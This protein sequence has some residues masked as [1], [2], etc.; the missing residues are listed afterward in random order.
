SNR[1]PALVSWRS[2]IFFRKP[3]PTFRDHALDADC[4]DNGRGREQHEASMRGVR[5][6]PCIREDLMS[7]SRRR[8][9]E[10]SL[11]P[12][13]GNGLIDRR[14]LL[15]R[16]IAFAGAMGAAGT[17]T[18]AAAEP[19]KDE[20]WSLEFGEVT[21]ALQTPSQFEKNVVRSL[22]NPNGEFR[23]SHAR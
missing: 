8:G 7:Q 2:M 17:V 3:I 18:G 5:E 9:R 1:H 14:A 4:V 19:L 21:P 20:K 22:S 13:A 23:N 12:V 6:H 16:G 10:P 15:G 11:D